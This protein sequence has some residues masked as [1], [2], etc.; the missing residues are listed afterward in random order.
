[1]DFAIVHKKISYMKC[2]ITGANKGI[3]F[4][5]QSQL[6]FLQCLWIF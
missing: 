4:E 2:L 1:M 6:G 5:A 3:G